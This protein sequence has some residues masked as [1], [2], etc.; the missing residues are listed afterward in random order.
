MGSELAAHPIDARASDQLVILG[1]LRRDLAGVMQVDGHEILRQPDRVIVFR[2]RVYDDTEEAFQHVSRRFAHRGYTAWLREG[3]GGSHEVVA[4][5]G[6]HDARAPSPVLN[7]VLFVATVLVVLWV[8]AGQALAEL[9]DVELLSPRD[10]LLL[11]LRNLHRGIPFAATLLGILLAHELSHYFV[12]RRYGA[13]VS[14]PYFIPMPN[15]LGT[16]GAV[17]IQ[18]APMRSRKAVFDIGVAGPI[19]GLIV[20]IPLLIY[21]LSLSSVSPPPVGLGYTQEGNSLLYLGLKYLVFRQILPSNG[22][23]VWLHPVAFAAW[24]GLFVTMINL[25]PVGQLDGGHVTY[26]LFGRKSQIVSTVAIVAM[27]LLGGWLI[28]QGDAEG[29]GFWMLWGFLNL[30]LNRRHTPALDDATGVSWRRVALGIVI[31]AAFVLMFMPSPLRQVLPAG[32]V[33]GVSL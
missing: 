13:P 19:G 12:G 18:R 15:F 26:A 25:L 11:P 20:A 22:L 28:F 23:D 9:P 2:G 10:A 33:S 8:G 4:T 17:I 1:Q 32:A 24:A 5:K 14:L 30:I 27:F 16:M 6:V 31:A 29:G 7:I 3:K 21:G